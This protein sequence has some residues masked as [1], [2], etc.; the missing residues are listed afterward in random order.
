M[1]IV[2]Y[3][4]LRTY[5]PTE[6]I[7]CDDGVSIFISDV[8][9]DCTTGTLSIT[10]TNNGKFSVNGYFIHVT[11]ES[12]AELA[13]I[14]LSWD[15][16]EEYGGSIYGNTNSISFSNITCVSNCENI[17]VPADSSDIGSLV[18][19]VSRYGNSL[20]KVE[21]IPT[22]IQEIENKKRLVSCSNAKIAE[23]LVCE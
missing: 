23:T 2:V 4:W 10:A 14:D 17:L 3:Q 22:R 5:V 19:N 18:F 11:N 1:S 21:I 8:S 6:S 20:A 12:D 9:Y 13:T 15:I 7:E 16:L